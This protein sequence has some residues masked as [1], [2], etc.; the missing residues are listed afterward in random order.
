MVRTLYQAGVF[1]VFCVLPLLGVGPAVAAPLT[2]DE[3]WELRAAAHPVPPMGWMSWYRGGYYG[4]GPTEAMVRAVLDQMQTNGWKAAGYRYVNL[5][6]GW[7]SVR[8]RP[9]GR[10][11]WN[12]DKFPSGLPALIADCH[13]L[14]FR[15][16]IY[17][18]PNEFVEGGAGVG[19]LGYFEQDAQT[20]AD[21]GIDYIKFDPRSPPGSASA[22]QDFTAAVARTGRPMFLHSYLQTSFDEWVPRNLNSFRKGLDIA[23][24]GTNEIW[25]QFM[26][27]LWGVAYQ[28]AYVRPG[29][30]LDMET[31]PLSLGNGWFRTEWLR[32]LLSMYAILAAPMFVSTVENPLHHPT[33]ALALDPDVL[34]INQDPAVNPPRLVKTNAF[35]AMVWARPLGP[36]GSGVLAVCLF[37]SNIEQAQTLEVSW[38]EL[39]LPQSA[40]MLVYD[41]WHKTNTFANTA[42]ER[43]LPPGSATLLRLVPWQEPVTR[44]Y[45]PG[46]IQLSDYDWNLEA[47][48]NGA[49][50]DG[51]TSRL[52]HGW[53]SASW[54]RAIGRNRT[55]AGQ[56]L[57]IR[58]AGGTNVYEQGLSLRTGVQLEYPLNEEGIR[59]GL[60]FGFQ[61]P[62]PPS[63]RVAL[64]IF[65]DG[66][67][68]LKRTV[69][70]GTRVPIELEVTGRTNLILRA[71]SRSP[72]NQYQLTLGN[73]WLEAVAGT[74]QASILQQSARGVEIL[75]RGRPGQ[76]V[77]LERS[78]DL[79]V[80][81]PVASLKLGSLPAIHS[82]PPS[83]GG[84]ARFYR[85]IPAAPGSAQSMPAP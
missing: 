57:S 13:A 36:V 85:A 46:L 70:Y 67:L 38:A 77:Q 47:T 25:T 53:T 34:A 73:L 62:E 48:T 78:T 5:D 30:Y 55:E 24:P 16:G 44:L 28:A 74:P 17:T 39:G 1:W 27:N 9:D 68:V 18:E 42:L 12:E 11:T 66:D 84:G 83:N 72:T 21:W 51:A 58:R 29:F 33:D 60:D 23:G 26:S 7:A 35:G 65:L 37:N 63:A 69:A 15:V 10:I 49:A 8:R 14:G 54:P 52:S 82:D 31:I 41:C 61:P 64:S 40:P 43:H 50:T 79:R 76:R 3:H 45:P 71:V 22:I 59:L 80:W 20:F 19:S 2:V 75:V 4:T 6:A 81:E 32:G 56:P